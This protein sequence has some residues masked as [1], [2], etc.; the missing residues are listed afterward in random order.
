VPEMMARGRRLWAS[1]S[2]P[3]V[4][5]TRRSLAAFAAMALAEPKRAKGTDFAGW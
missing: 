1:S 5:T 4:P 2:V 3:R